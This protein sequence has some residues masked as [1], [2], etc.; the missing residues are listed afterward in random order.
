M[1]GSARK[2]NIMATI[3]YRSK[4]YI[5]IGKYKENIK[6]FNFIFLSSIMAVNLGARATY[7][8]LSSKLKKFPFDALPLVA[9]HV[10]R[11]RLLIIVS[12]YYNVCLHL[13]TQE[14]MKSKKMFNRKAAKIL[15]IFPFFE[16][17]NFFKILGQ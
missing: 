4:E 1:L 11:L 9:C 5:K 15:T 17:Y 7:R 12:C 3:F 13:F 14:S 10:L 16:L 8:F 2:T 6:I